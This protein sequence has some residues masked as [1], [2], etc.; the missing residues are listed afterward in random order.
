MV[1]NVSFISFLSPSLGQE[2]RVE[3]TKARGGEYT[4]GI[5]ILASTVLYVIQIPNTNIHPIKSTPIG[6]L[7]LATVITFQANTTIFNFLFCPGGEETT[8]KAFS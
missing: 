5:I 8:S 6:I 3:E 4:S 2:E 1:M 7:G